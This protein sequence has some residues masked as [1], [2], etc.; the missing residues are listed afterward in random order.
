MKL[1]FSIL[2]KLQVPP[3]IFRQDLTQSILVLFQI[4]SHSLPPPLFF[5]SFYNRVFFFFFEYLVI[6]FPS[7]PSTHLTSIYLRILQSDSETAHCCKQCLI[8]DYYIFQL[9]ILAFH[10]YVFLFHC[11]VFLPAGHKA[12]PAFQSLNFF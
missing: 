2:G 6:I 11:V 7:S 8:S 5:P 4:P 9:K 12:L 1:S 10:I 3:T